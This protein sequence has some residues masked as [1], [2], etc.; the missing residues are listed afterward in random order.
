MLP[1]IDLDPLL[2]ARTEADFWCA[3]ERASDQAQ[4]RPMGLLAIWTPAVRTAVLLDGGSRSRSRLV[5][6]VEA[7]RAGR[8]VYL[9]RALG[10]LSLSQ[11]RRCVRSG[12][13]VI[14]QRDTLLHW[15]VVDDAR[16]RRVSFSDSMLANWELGLAP[17]IRETA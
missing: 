15:R 5:S 11:I 10:P 14:S 9:S 13:W 1:K 17:M 7:P 6:L 3:F 16:N 4:A 12:Q 8:E 2:S